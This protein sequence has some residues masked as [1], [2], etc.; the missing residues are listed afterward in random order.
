MPTTIGRSRP[1]S[2]FTPEE[3]DRRLSETLKKEVQEYREFWQPMIRE[4]RKQDAESTPKKA[5]KA[6]R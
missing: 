6:T 5:R 1:V 2:R 4:Q 3:I